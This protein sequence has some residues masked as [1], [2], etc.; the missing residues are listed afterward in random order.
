MISPL[1][2]VIVL[3]E[4]LQQLEKIGVKIIAYADDVVLLATGKFLPTLSEQIDGALKTLVRWT[5][6]CGLNINPQKTEMVLFTN[7]RKIPQFDT[8]SVGGTPLK[9]SDSARYLGLILDRKLTWKMNIEERIKKANIAFYS[10][11]RILGKTWGP[12]PRIIFWMYSYY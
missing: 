5:R 9:I 7:K 2:W 4:A 6:N 10:C 8:P 3:N 1:L 12:S 11:S